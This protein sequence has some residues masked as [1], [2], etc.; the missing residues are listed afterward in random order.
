MKV[1]IVS[2]SHGLTMELEKIEK[3]HKEEADL[4]IHCG[5]SE[6]D[7]DHVAIIDYVT[8]RGNCDRDER[9][10]N[11]AVK[12]VGNQNLFITH[13][14][15]YSVKS[16]LMSLSY[17][18]REVGADIVCFGHSHQSWCRNGYGYP[19][20]QPGKYSASAWEKRKNICDSKH[21]GKGLSIESV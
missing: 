20:Y 6:L 12:R 14:H 11:E 9:F 8:V 18:A 5:D 10:P 1:L 3:R 21:F 13:G 4:F 16:D 7:A 15:R 19:F 2:D 17:K